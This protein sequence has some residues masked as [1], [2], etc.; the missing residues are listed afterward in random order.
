MSDKTQTVK[1]NI[2]AET[3]KATSEIKRLNGQISK[4]KKQTLNTT[5][6][7]KKT[8]SA[9][10]KMSGSFAQLG[11]HLARLA[12][13]YA[14]FQAVTGVVTK[15]AAFEQQMKTLGVISGA[16]GDELQALEAKAKKL[17]ES[18]VF[19][20]SQVASAMTEMGR[21]GFTAQQQLEG[22]KGV[23][24]LAVVGNVD[25]AEASIY[26]STAMNG[27]GLEAKDIGT[28]SD[29]MAKAANDSAQSVTELARAYTKVA[30]V[31]T[32]FGNSMT[33]TTALLE[34]MA[35]AGIKA[36]RGGTQLK[37]AMLR[38]SANNQVKQY[39]KDLSNAAGGISTA[40][41]DANGNVKPFIEQLRVLKKAV[42]GLTPELRNA[43]I[44]RIFG[45]EATTS[46]QFLLKN[47]D[48]VETKL[49]ALN[50]SYGYASESARKMMD[51]LTGS[52]HELMSALE[53]LAIK[54]GAELAP[55]LIA[56]AD[57]ATE[58]IKNID[59][60][61][62]KDFSKSMGDLVT[63][64]GDF[65]TGAAEAVAVAFKMIGIFQDITGASNKQV[66][67]LALLIYNAKKLIK[68]FKTFN[69]LMAGGGLLIGAAIAAFVILIAKI[70]EVKAEIEDLNNDLKASENRWKKLNEAI[71]GF[72]ELD[73]AT[74]S[75]K[76]VKDEME[77]LNGVIDK[78]KYAI[79]Q[80]QKTI[81]SLQSGL[82]P[83]TD[84]EKT[85]VEAYKNKINA[86][87][88][89]IAN[90]KKYLK[91][92]KDIGVA[93]TKRRQAEIKAINATRAATNKL[94]KEAKLLNDS[95]LKS[96]QKLI[97][98]YKDRK[99]TAE[100]TLATLR[101]KE[102]RYVADMLK[103]EKKLSDTRKKYAN[104]RKKLALD[105]NTKLADLSAMGLSDLQKYNDAQR[106]ADEQ[107]AKA[108]EAFL[109]G[110]LV[111]AKSY[112]AEYDNLVAISAGE[113][114]SHEEEVNKYDEKTHKWKKER[115]KVID[116][117]Q[118]ATTDDAIANEN[119][120]YEFVKK[121][122]G[123][124]ER[125]AIAK[126]KNEMALKKA[127]QKLVEAEIDLQIKAIELMAKMIA[128]I[129][130]VKW[131]EDLA[132]AK[133]EIKGIEQNIDAIFN[134]QRQMKIQA[135][136]DP[137]SL[138]DT[139]NKIA[140]DVSQ[141][142]GK[143]KIE[144]EIDPKIEKGQA[145]F[146]NFVKTNEKTGISTDVDVKTDKAQGGFDK[147]IAT[148]QKTG[149]TTDLLLT[150]VDSY[151]KFDDISNHIS[152]TKPRTDLVLLTAA[153]NSKDNAFVAKAS[154]PIKRRL[155]TYEVFHAASH[156]YQ[157][158]G[159]ILPRFAEG[160]HLDDGVGHSR[161]TGQL[162]GY[163]GGDKIKALLEAGEFI[164][165]KEAVRSL[166][167]ERLNVLNQGML[168]RFNT[169]GVVASIP[170]FSSGGE[171]KPSRTV[172]LNLN[173]GGKTFTTISDEYVATALSDYLTRS[174]L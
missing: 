25:L 124:E 126:I 150:T 54:I 32:Q 18:T 132:G 43:Q 59:P 128:K 37:I 116:K 80:Y 174:T 161:K 15:F 73:K 82:L 121:I 134:K 62:I 92:T 169:G 8:T 154:R 122:S 78:S 114:I 20:A 159:L 69:A 157:N 36:E 149:L 41:Y 10:R 28:V 2:K 137:Q 139:A 29:I 14:G 58:F 4:L 42:A 109:K 129:T 84:A 89:I 17:G 16:T 52:Y 96:V 45:T 33:E 3:A 7:M 170:R 173:I 44:S 61:T 163:G 91:L 140:D 94:S 120:R 88:T 162:S 55:A 131:D 57:S 24:D 11:E 93:V 119:R 35:Q 68:A 99:N 142:A 141:K 65:V 152:S 75:L 81:Y 95:E 97:D 26:A 104:D 168:P 98:K 47:I 155:D 12:V 127:Q 146:T 76:D 102:R 74:S 77:N 138:N 164:L 115:I 67:V 151:K 5:A 60:Q 30:P 145:K 66:I 166:G 86:E 39:L 51:T 172:E 49:K 100:N 87:K 112:L 101:N 1:I 34:V 9:V 6:G 136:P 105:H 153:A 130:G 165:R 46:V 64:I 56:S 90:A 118:K 79:E 147:F 13:Y 50:K 70:Q 156:G 111:M 148:N 48:M 83:M 27:F 31:A 85:L 125:R 106:R 158:G 23:L 22:I 21:A 110:N 160:G 108:K 113:E 123:E 135:T 133:A 40:M 171:A 144:P 117:A 63:D 53:G 103:L 38:L 72:G 71:Q 143:A 167:L 19:S 107:L